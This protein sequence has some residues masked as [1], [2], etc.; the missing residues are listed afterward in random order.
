MIERDT[1]DG[2]I[3]LDNFIAISPV[4]ASVVMTLDCY[5]FTH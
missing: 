1:S 2:I 4:I 3:I 5:V